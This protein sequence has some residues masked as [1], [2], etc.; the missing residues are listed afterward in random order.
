MATANKI[1]DALAVLDQAIYALG[2]LPGADGIAIKGKLIKARD[3]FAGLIKSVEDEA[4]N[5]AIN[6]DLGV[7]EWRAFVDPI[8]WKA[9]AAVETM[10]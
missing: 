8:I 6:V 4:A 2:F 1:P 9:L 10:K 3:A 7:S 5:R